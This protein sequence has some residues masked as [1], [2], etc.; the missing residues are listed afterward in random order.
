MSRPVRLSWIEP[1]SDLGIGRQCDLLG[2][3]RSSVY[4]RPI[5]ESEY[6]LVLMQEID[7]LYLQYPFYGRPRLTHELRKR[8]YQVNEKRVGRLMA[9]MS[10]QAIYPKK[11]LS[12]PAI[13]H[14]VYPYLLRNLPVTRPRQVYAM[15]ITYMGLKGGFLYLCAVMDWYSRFVLSWQLSNSLSVDFCLEAV[16]D[17]FEKYGVCEIFNTDQGSQFTSDE[18]TQKVI[19]AGSQMSMDGKGRALDNVFVERLWRTIKYEYLFLHAF[20]DGHELYRGLKGY[21]DFY[22]NRRDHSALGR[23]PPYQIFLNS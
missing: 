18:F 21:L 5:P 12:K 7:K 23:K 4:Y 17:A 20:N 16:V 10:I 2:L 19:K 15:D 9:L 8:G 22:N 3:S 13:G 11:N 1:G 6:N 14:K